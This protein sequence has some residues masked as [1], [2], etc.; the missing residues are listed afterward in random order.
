VRAMSFITVGLALGCSAPPQTKEETAVHYRASFSAEPGVATKVVFPWLGDGAAFAAQSGLSVSDGG[1]FAL[2]TD[3]EGLGLAVSGQGDVSV[4][5]DDA[6]VTGVGSGKAVP[7]ASL[8]RLAPDG[9][10]TEYLFRVNKGGKALVNVDF[11]YTASRDCGAECGGTRSWKYQGSV[12]LA[13]QQVSLQYS[14]EKR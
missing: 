14:E 7:E 6:H 4:S 10:T 5:F 12:G 13:L 11:E 9:G 1:S 8:T 2:E 3:N